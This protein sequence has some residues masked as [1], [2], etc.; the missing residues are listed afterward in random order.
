VNTPLVA[1]HYNLPLAK[2]TPSTRQVEGFESRCDW[3]N[4][5]KGVSHGSH[6]SDEGIDY[7]QK[8]AIPVCQ[9]RGRGEG[10][11]RRS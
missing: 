6:H 3:R 4:G 9:E 10:R 8:T 11:W 2:M 5:T 7:R 1:R